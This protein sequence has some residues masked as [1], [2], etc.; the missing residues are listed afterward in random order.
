MFESH[1]ASPLSALT[2]GEGVA[3]IP[4]H[5]GEGVLRGVVG[6]RQ[7]RG[8]ARRAGGHW[9]WPR[10]RGLG[11]ASCLCLEEKEKQMY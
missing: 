1:G 2:V 10:G 5:A 9:D 3:H 4:P 11:G 8:G 7:G 6:V